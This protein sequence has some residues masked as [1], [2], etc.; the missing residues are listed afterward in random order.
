MIERAEID[1]HRV[2]VEIGIELRLVDLVVCE[3]AGEL[4]RGT[5]LRHDLLHRRVERLIAEI[6]AILDLS[7]K[8]ADRPQ[9]LDRGRRE[10]GDEGVLQGGIFQPMTDPGFIGNVT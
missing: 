6:G 7:L 10:D 1:L 5:R 3:D 8:A 2:A 9:S 4:G